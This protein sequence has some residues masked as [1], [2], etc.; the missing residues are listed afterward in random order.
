MNSLK[1]ILCRSTSRFYCSSLLTRRI[2]T[3]Q[4]LPALLCKSAPNLLL[5]ASLLWRPLQ[6]SPGTCS[7]LDAAGPFLFMVTARVCWFG[8]IFWD[9]CAA[10]ICLPALLSNR[11]LKV[12]TDITNCWRSPPAWLRLLF[13]AKNGPKVTSRCCHHTLLWLLRMIC[14][15]VFEP[16]ES[17]FWFFFTKKGFSCASINL[18]IQTYEGILRWFLL[19]SLFLHPFWWESKSCHFS[20]TV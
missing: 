13:Q 7:W 16:D 2:V 17:F 18:I 15:V 3:W 8:W 11:S 10:E 5:G 9:F 20:R 12:E 1:P 14:N 4:F 19:I 6:I